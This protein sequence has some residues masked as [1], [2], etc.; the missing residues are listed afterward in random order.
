MIVVR[1]LAALRGHVA[2]ARRGGAR[3]ALVPTMGA[4]HQG[5]VALVDAARR[6]ADRVAVSIFVT[7]LQFD[8]AQDLARYPRDEANDLAILREAG[9]DLVWL[10]G[11]DEMYPAGAATR[12]E[13]RGPA[14][15]WEGAHRTGHFGGVATVCTKL[16]LQTGADVA[17]FGEKDWQQVQVVRR[18][19]RDLDLP[20]A[21]VGV[22]TLRESDGLALSS[23]NRFLTPAERR[24]APRLAA[25]LHSAAAAY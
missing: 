15:R 3:L 5:H 1:E 19:V 14:E 20:I 22:P 25:A 4:L 7:P 23:R 11:V 12:V 17:M 2:A 13:I 21:I 6:H 16:F 9:C 10:P 8:R 24:L 18:V